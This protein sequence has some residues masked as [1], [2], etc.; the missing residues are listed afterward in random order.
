MQRYYVAKAGSHQP[1][2]PWSVEQIR[3]KLAQGQIS[4]DFLYFT[5]GMPQWAPLH[6]LPGLTNMACPPVPAPPRLHSA[7]SSGGLVWS[8]LATLFCCLPFGV[9]SIVYAVKA[10]DL[11]KQGHYAEADAA[12]AAAGKWRWWS[13]IG[14]FIYIVLCAFA[15]LAAG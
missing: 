10:D 8:I 1:M 2:G 5:E 4:Y 7:K 11:Y 3:E 6:S 9:V 12:A 13:F 15:G 14:F